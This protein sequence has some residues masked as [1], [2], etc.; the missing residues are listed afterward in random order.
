MIIWTTL[1]WLKFIIGWTV[2]LIVLGMLFAHRFHLDRLPMLRPSPVN[3]K[4]Y[5]PDRPAR[6]LGDVAQ[7]NCAVPINAIRVKDEPGRTERHGNVT[8]YFAPDGTVIGIAVAA[9]DGETLTIYDRNGTVLGR[10][11]IPGPIISTD[12]ESIH[13]IPVVPG[14]E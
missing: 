4:C 7:C 6:L 10:Y 14:G 9:D 2:A 1:K 3:I 12:P 11:F 8:T 5:C 13:P